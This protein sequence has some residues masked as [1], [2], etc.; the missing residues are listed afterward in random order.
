MNGK[1]IYFAS[2]TC[3]RFDVI[4]EVKARGDIDVYIVPINGRYGNP[5]SL[6][7]VA[8]T[9]RLAP[10]VAIPCHFWMFVEHGSEPWVF[11]DEAPK[12]CPD[13]KVRLLQ[14]GEPLTI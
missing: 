5:D 6:Q 13:T 2:D 8:M 12:E 3:P 7:A 11:M 10:K 1:R 14:V 9:R 4:D